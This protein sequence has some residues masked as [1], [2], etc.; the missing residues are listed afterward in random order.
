MAKRSISIIDLQFKLGGPA[1]SLMFIDS[2]RSRVLKDKE[3]A[4]MDRWA[5]AFQSHMAKVG[6]PNVTCLP[7]P[8][9]SSAQV[10]DHAG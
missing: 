1:A 4:M 3:V 9:N 2:L 5:R 8:C 10:I 7:M 6:T